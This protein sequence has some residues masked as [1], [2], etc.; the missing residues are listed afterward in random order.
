M[1]FY[2]QKLLHLAIQFQPSAE[3]W[4]LYNQLNRIC[5]SFYV[6]RII[7]GQVIEIVTNIV[8]VVL[9][10]EEYNN[11]STAVI[12]DVPEAQLDTNYIL[13]TEKRMHLSFTTA[14]R[15]WL[16]TSKL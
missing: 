4:L 5:N 6:E 10:H 12:Q 1:P 15:M 13:I 8:I 16:V 3:L 9:V 2:H 7:K 14:E 11:Y